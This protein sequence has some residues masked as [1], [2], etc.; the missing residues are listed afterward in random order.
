MTRA[1]QQIPAHGLNPD[2]LLPIFVNKTLLKHN[3]AHSFTYHLWLLCSELGCCNRDSWR[4]QS[5]KYLL[6]GSQQEMFADFCSKAQGSRKAWVEVGS[7]D[8][9]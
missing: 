5:P 2:W 1:D 3:H 7:K 6:S 8:Q 4:A 9:S